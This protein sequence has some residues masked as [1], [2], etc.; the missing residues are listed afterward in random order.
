M[1]AAKERSRISAEPGAHALAAAVY[2]AAM[3]PAGL[4]E[5]AEPLQKAA[6]A[7]KKITGWGL[8]RFS[9]RALQ[10]IAVRL[11]GSGGNLNSIC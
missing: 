6:Y 8:R 1:S 5:V 11:P 10:G 4:R 2:L 7:R 3:G 9:R